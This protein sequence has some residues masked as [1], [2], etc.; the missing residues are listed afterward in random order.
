MII[1][2]EGATSEDT[3]AAK[4]SLQALARSWG[5]EITEAPAEAA[6]AGGAAHHDDSKV[7]DPVAMASLV[8]SIPSAAVAVV[9]LADRIGKRR[10]AQELI[11]HAQ[12]LAAQQVNVYLMSQG[13]TTDLRSLTPD[14]LLDQLTDEDAAG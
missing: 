10:R 12:H 5:L 9:D 6:R 7:I 2:L 8:M 13:R 4:R 11:D 3:G 1:R 14:Q